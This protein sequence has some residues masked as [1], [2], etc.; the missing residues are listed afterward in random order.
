MKTRL[1]GAVLCVLSLSAIQLSGQ[2][3][4]ER[5]IRAAEEA[6][7]K[8]IAEGDVAAYDRLAADDFQFIT[9]AGGVVKKSERLAVLKKGPAPG[10]AAAPDSIRFYGDVAVVTG[11]QGVGGVV[12]YTRVWVRQKNAWRAVVT[13]ATAIAQPKP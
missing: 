1:V 9:G 11:R 6:M 2:S 12:R 5:Q 13:Q 8:A 10:F 4:D 3:Q 7:G